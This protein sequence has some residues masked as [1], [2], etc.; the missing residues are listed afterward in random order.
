MDLVV[1]L[2]WLTAV[3]RLAVTPLVTVLG[4]RPLDRGS[5]LHGHNSEALRGT[6]MDFCDPRQLAPSQQMALGRSN[7]PRG[8]DTWN[9]N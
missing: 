6:H 2:P 5:T 8:E 4:E 7:H 1:K 9:Q 3:S